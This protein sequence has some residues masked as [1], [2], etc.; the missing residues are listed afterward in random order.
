MKEKIIIKENRL[1]ALELT[2][3]FEMNLNCNANTKSEK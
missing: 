1:Y 2:I 3:D